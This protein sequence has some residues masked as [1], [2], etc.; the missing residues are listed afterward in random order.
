MTRMR[1]RE[2]S[3]SE[4]EPVNGSWVGGFVDGGWPGGGSMVS[5]TAAVEVRPNLSV[6]VYE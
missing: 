6:M 2:E 5:V 4:A 1:A 3:P